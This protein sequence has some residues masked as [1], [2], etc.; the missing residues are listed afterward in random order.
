VSVRSG[1]K[2]L[3]ALGAVAL[4]AAGCSDRSGAGEL[5]E[6]EPGDSA[7][8]SQ[9]PSPSP[10]D[11]AVGAY[12]AMW[13]DTAVASHTSDVDHPRLDDHATGEALMVLEFVMQGHAEKDHVARGGPKHD[14]TVVQ[15]SDSRRELNDCM[16]Q[17][18]W[19]MYDK[20]GELVDNVPGSHTLV[21]ATVERRAEGWIVTDLIMHGSAT[22]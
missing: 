21:D 7:S 11:P 15:S 2:Q 17:T 9:S 3:A 4:L 10:T 12:V 13:E 1:A 20:N 19:M 18:N 16:D 22:C 5:A 8:V 14:V 6:D